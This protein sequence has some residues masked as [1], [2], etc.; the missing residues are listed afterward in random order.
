MDRERLPKFH[1]D[2][3]EYYE[4]EDIERQGSHMSR[5]DR[6]RER[7][8]ER[9]SPPRERQFNRCSE[10]RQMGG[11]PRYA[12]GGRKLSFCNKIFKIN[13]ECAASSRVQSLDRRMMRRDPVLIEFEKDH[14][15]KA[16]MYCNKY[17]M[18]DMDERAPPKRAPNTRS[19]SMPRQSRYGDRLMPPPERTGS[20]DNRGST[21]G[22]EDNMDD[23]PPRKGRKQSRPG[24]LA[25]APRL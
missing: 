17:A 8:R 22:Y 9:Q 16:P 11:S 14:S 23:M 5:R 24:K 13:F 18:D 15:C 2:P 19:Q 1:A 7:E 20:R 25:V 4:D 6:M 12:R 10:D 3:D 21:G